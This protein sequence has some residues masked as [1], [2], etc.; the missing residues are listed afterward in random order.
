MIFINRAKID[1]D[2]LMSIT[3]NVQM[4]K[5]VNPDFLIDETKK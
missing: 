2:G 1:S 5:T 3:F 4:K